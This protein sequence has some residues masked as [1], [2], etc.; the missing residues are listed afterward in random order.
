MCLT[1]LRAKKVISSYIGDVI[2]IKWD[3]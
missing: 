2:V 1:S 3:E